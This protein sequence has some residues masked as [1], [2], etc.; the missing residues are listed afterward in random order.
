[1]LIDQMVDMKEWEIDNVNF[2]WKF[3]WQ[4]VN[5]WLREYL[6]NKTLKADEEY[7]NEIIAKISS[8]I[9]E[10][11]YLFKI[12]FGDK[13][14]GQYEEV[15]KKAVGLFISLIDALSEDDTSRVNQIALEIY[16]GIEERSKYLFELNPYWVRSKLNEYI[17][18]LTNMTIQQIITFMEKDYKNSIAI[19]DRILK[20]TMMIGDYLAQGTKKYF[21]NII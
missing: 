19:Y 1:M 16:Q 14:V 8:I 11:I 21:N 7:L 2:K 15:M 5:S 12:F 4:Q 9:E 20:Y 13:V 10:Y 18:Y 6:I 3:L 17:F